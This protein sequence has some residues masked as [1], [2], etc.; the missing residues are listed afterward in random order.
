MQETKDNSEMRK[1]EL[2]HRID[3]EEKAAD[4]IWQA[5]CLKLD[6]RCLIF[7]N[8]VMFGLI[9]CFFCM[10]KLSRD[11][12]TEEQMV[13]LSLLSTITA[14]FLPSPNIKER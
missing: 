8:Q 5:S 4:N 1:R 11:M 2:E 12:S 13:Y 9:L 6:R 14:I 7:V 10:Y 3:L